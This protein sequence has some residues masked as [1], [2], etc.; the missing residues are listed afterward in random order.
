[1]VGARDEAQRRKGGKYL[2]R[3]NILSLE[4]KK[5]GEGKGGRYW[6]KESILVMEGI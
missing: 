1:M 4:E 6:K 3:E 5:S 2:E